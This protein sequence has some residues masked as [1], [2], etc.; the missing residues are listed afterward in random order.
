MQA[1]LLGAFALGQRNVLV[2]TGDPP[3]L[4]DYPNLT[5]VYDVDAIGLVRIMA[6]LNSGRDL[7]GTAIAAPTSFLIGVGANP[8]AVDLERE[9]ARF[10]QKVQGG[11]EFAMTQPV[12]DAR[13]LERFLDAIKPWRIP[14]LVGILPLASYRNAEFLHNEVPGMQIPDAVRERMRRAPTGEAAAQTGV[15]IAREALRE[16]RGLVDG[17]YVM[18][19]LGRYQSALRVLEVLGE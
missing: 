17:V 6:D 10:A 1:D 16:T 4:G 13:L 18:P 7:A 15:D 5:A 14:V 8:G 19:P 11:A 9:V 2:V 12:Y 3:K